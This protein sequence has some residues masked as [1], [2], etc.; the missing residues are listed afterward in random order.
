MFKN[1]YN[2]FFVTEHI[3]HQVVHPL[4]EYHRQQIL[5][6]LCGEL[7]NMFKVSDYLQDVKTASLYIKLLFVADIYS[8]HF[9]NDT[10][11][12]SAIDEYLSNIPV[13][14]QVKVKHYITTNLIPSFERQYAEFNSYVNNKIYLQEP[15]TLNYN[16]ATST[17]DF[18]YNNTNLSIKLDCYNKLRKHLNI[19]DNKI[20][21][22]FILLLRYDV[23]TT[24][25]NYIQSIV[26][27][28]NINL[29][30]GSTS[31]LTAHTPFIATNNYDI[32]KY[33]GCCGNINDIT[34]V[35]GTYLVL[36]SNMSHRII[37]Y[38]K[39]SEAMQ[40]PLCIFYVTTEDHTIIKN[41]G[42]LHK[43]YLELHVIIIKNKYD[44]RDIV[45]DN[46]A[47]PIVNT[48]DAT[49]RKIVY[50][51]NTLYEYAYFDQEYQINLVHPVIEYRRSKIIN[52]IKHIFNEAYKV[53]NIPINKLIVITVLFIWNNIGRQDPVVPI[54]DT[55]N[56]DVVRDHLLLFITDTKL[57]KTIITNVNARLTQYVQPAYTKLL[58]WFHQ[59]KYTN[60][61][62]TITYTGSAYVFQYKRHTTTIPLSKSLH[63]KLLTRLQQN[64]ID[65]KLHDVYIF[66]LLY[67]YWLLDAGNQ[68]LA[69]STHF[70]KAL[71]TYHVNIELFGS[72]INRFYDGYC[73]LFYDIE[74]YY[75]S[76]GDFFKFK[77]ISGA[78]V[79]NPPFDNVMMTS[80]AKKL[81]KYLARADAHH[82][83]LSF[84][85]IIP[86]WD[87]KT[88]QVMKE[89]C[90]YAEKAVYGGKYE[91]IEILNASPYVKKTYTVCKND[92][93]YY[94]YSQNKFINASDTYILLL[95]N[96][97]A[98]VIVIE[99]YLPLLSERR[100]PFS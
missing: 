98:D 88:R 72:A 4:I 74:K 93:P 59:D 52:H 44:T 39:N 7:D 38:M 75:G 83:Q 81:V 24:S 62:F 41:S 73:S 28:Y 77:P 70:K 19:Y 60:R 8:R 94:N 25:N 56:F 37:D 32:T 63:L 58:T 66:V 78:Y 43:K 91:T 97:Y 36:S 67:R 89:K 79:A 12:L 20:F 16:T 26:A 84:I 65:S 90:H 57:I 33:F 54:T 69:I 55:F 95:Q 82:K 35:T 2:S 11:N 68:Q 42:Y 15:Y 92:F 87:D 46:V 51:H 17:I 30:I 96:K 40:K 29:T 76:L 34:L 99:D 71:H 10:P 64:N 45:L 47:A 5:K 50:I 14:V 85:V 48:Y 21:Y 22:I 23:P 100:N 27:K 49:L 3:S 6:N 61:E 86:I 1:E 31:P 53:T 13:D 80:V 18:T 9:F